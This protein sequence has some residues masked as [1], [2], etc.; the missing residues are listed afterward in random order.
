MRLPQRRLRLYTWGTTSK[1]TG[2]NHAQETAPCRRARRVGV[3]GGPGAKHQAHGAAENRCAGRQ[4]R[5]GSGPRGGACRLEYRSAHASR[6]RAGHSAGAVSYTHLDVYKRQ[7]LLGDAVEH[8]PIHVL[9]DQFLEPGVVRERFGAEEP[10][11]HLRRREHLG[12]VLGPDL[13]ELA[14]VGRAQERKGRDQGAG[15]HTG[16]DF[17]PGAVATLRPADQQS[18]AEGAVARA[19]R[20]REILHHGPAAGGTRLARHAARARHVLAHEAQHVGGDFIAPK[21]GMRH[22]GNAD[23][24]DEGLGNGV[25]KDLRGARAQRQRDEAQHHELPGARTHGPLY[26]K[27][28]PQPRRTLCKVHHPDARFRHVTLIYARIGSLVPV[29]VGGVNAR[30]GLGS[31]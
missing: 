23:I 25:A 28:A 27:A 12:V 1:E 16:H 3:G 21:T 19:A 10:G 22:A 24:V 8:A 7:I 6:H 26:S 17:E 13:L 2:G 30:A 29:E 31:A 9:R 11:E 5:I 14:I 20:Q 15:A 4:L 18:T